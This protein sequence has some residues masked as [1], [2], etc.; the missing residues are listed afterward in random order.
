MQEL[1][2]FKK[3]IFM[4][5]N[6][7]LLDQ[8]IKRFE[9]FPNQGTLFYDITPVFSNPQLF[10][11]VLTQMAQFIKAINAEAIVCPEARG[12]IFGGALASKT[13]LPLVLVRKANK[14]PGQLISASYDL[15]YRKHAVLEMSTTSLIQANNAKRCVIVDDVL[16]TA[17]TVAA[18][19]QLLKQLNGETVGYCFLI[20]LKKLNGKAKLQP[21]VVSK[22]L[23]HY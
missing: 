8:A 9:N 10:N 4:D 12:F 20:E 7:K 23:L 11:F 21:N 14:L 3:K 22:I 13:Q 19:D 5:Q 1:T 15:E 18:I 2:V 17:G 16:A 6:F